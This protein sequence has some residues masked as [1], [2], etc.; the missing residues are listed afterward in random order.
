MATTT[1]IAALPIA[2]LV[3]PLSGYLT[4]ISARKGRKADV[5]STVVDTAKR[6]VEMVSGQLV[7]LEVHL[8]ACEKH[9]AACESQLAELNAR[10]RQLEVPH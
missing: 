1:W 2:A 10:V 8:A 5:E 7:S 3:A 6:V 4:L 9:S